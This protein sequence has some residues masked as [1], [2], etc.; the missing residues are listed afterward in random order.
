MNATADVTATQDAYAAA[1]LITAALPGPRASEV[2]A[3]TTRSPPSLTRLP[4][5]PDAGRGSSVED[6]NSNI[7]STSTPGSR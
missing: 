3:E 7:F 4:A 6:V 1:P 5:R 2:L